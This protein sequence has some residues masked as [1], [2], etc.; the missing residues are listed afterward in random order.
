MEQFVSMIW[1][2]HLYY[3]NLLLYSSYDYMQSL[4]LAD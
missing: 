1:I 4:N 3:N 2:I